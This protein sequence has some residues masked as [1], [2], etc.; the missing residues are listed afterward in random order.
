MK[1]RFVSNVSH[2]LRTPVTTSQLYTEL[3]RRRPERWRE[4]V[5]TLAREADHQAQLVED[6]LQ[7][8][9]IDAGRLEMQPRPTSLD[10]LARAAVAGHQ[11]LA[12]ARGLTLEYRPA[13]PGT[14]ASP[15]EPP[16]ALV[17]LDRGG[18]VLNNLVVNAIQYTPEGGQ[19]VVSTGQEEAE[20]RVGATVT[21][22]DDQS[23]HILLAQGEVTGDRGHRPAGAGDVFH[24]PCATFC[25]ET[26]RRVPGCPGIIGTHATF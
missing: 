9:C 5:N 1:S 17:D 18:Q 22:A 23:N 11:A 2:E 20:G 19:I 15:A 16:V 8:S 6:I 26:L 12:Q 7:I 3:R 13:E 21:V 24:S 10:E 14:A 25:W 4:Y